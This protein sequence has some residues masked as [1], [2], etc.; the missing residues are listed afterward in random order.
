M[1]KRVTWSSCICRG[2][3]TARGGRGPFLLFAPFTHS[4]WTLT[5]ITKACSVQTWAGVLCS[6]LTGW[7]VQ[8]EDSRSQLSC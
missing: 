2:C 8:M 7:G 6:Q 1:L 3:L 5:G 4:S